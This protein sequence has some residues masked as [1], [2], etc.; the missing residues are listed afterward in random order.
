[1]DKGEIEMNINIWKIPHGY[2]RHPNDIPFSI[3]EKGYIVSSFFDQKHCWK[4]C[5][6]S[7]WTNKKPKNLI[8][9]IDS[10]N[11]DV[12]FYNPWDGRFY[13]SLQEGWLVRDSLED[14]IYFCEKQ[15]A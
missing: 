8:S 14:I 4:L 7:V 10:A 6:W 3:Q 11:Y 15:K 1:M 9:D 13:L 2:L 5:N 12:I